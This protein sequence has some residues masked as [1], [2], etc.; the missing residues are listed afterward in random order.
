LRTVPGLLFLFVVPLFG[1]QSPLLSSSDLLK[2]ADRSWQLVEATSLAIPDLNRASTP[3]QESLKQ[4]R[5]NLRSRANHVGYTYSLL[6]NLRAYASLVDAVQKPYPL[7]GETMAQLVE[8]KGTVERLEIHFRSLLESAEARLRPADRDNLRR[9]EEAN[10]KLSSPVPGNPRVVFF[11]DSIT[12]FWRLNE[13]FQ[14]KDYVN[15]G[16]SGQV[17][18]EMLGR[19]KAD[20]IDLKPAAVVILAGTNDLA[21]NTPVSTITNNYIMMAELAKLHGIKVIFASVLPV[22]DYHKA[23]NPDW[24]R[25]KARPPASILALN[26]WM[27][28][29]SASQNHTYLDYFTALADSSGMLKA[30]MA[31]D[32]LHPNAAGYRAMAPLA[33]AAID[34][35]VS[36][37]AQP[38]KK[39]KRLFSK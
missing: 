5:T 12:D 10:Q 7:P 32:G 25:S 29:Y 8:L 28:R 18:G 39:K 2:L 16:I 38:E 36:G 20:V 11:G 30:D 14:N 13:Y 1:Q 26:D 34:K 4:A 17:T 9:F 22:S 6:T 37:I 33:Q 35:V 19:F 24:E 31:D 21:R 23:T 15:R 3:L 27:K